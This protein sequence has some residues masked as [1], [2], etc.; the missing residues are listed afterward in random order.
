MSLIMVV[1]LVR[2]FNA[3]IIGLGLGFIAG[4]ALLSVCYPLMVGR[5]L[6]IG[7]RSQLVAL[8]RPTL[9][10]LVLFFL[11]FKLKVFMV[12][13]SWPSLSLSVLVTLCLV[14]AAAFYA[15]LSSRQREQILR[16]VRLATALG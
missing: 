5:I 8:F 2:G 10:M 16:R 13:S 14:S 3:G 7:W 1:T 11:A 15:G 6:H 9:V 4:R 12:A